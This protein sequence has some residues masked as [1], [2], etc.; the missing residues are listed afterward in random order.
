MVTSDILGKYE[1]YNGHIYRHRS[2]RTRK[3]VCIAIIWSFVIYAQDRLSKLVYW[4]SGFVSN[5][6]CGSTTHLVAL[7]CDTSSE[8]Y[9]V[10]WILLFWSIIVVFSRLQ[11]KRNCPY[12]VLNGSKMHGQMR[13]SMKLLLLPTTT[14]CDD[15][16]CRYSPV[17]QLPYRV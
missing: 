15:I 11:S 14:T 1:R 3:C 7:E 2:G 9:R 4:M 10:A 12:S 16:Y 8:K 17:L 6:L 5:A 13:H